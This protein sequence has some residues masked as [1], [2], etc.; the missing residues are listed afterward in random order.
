MDSQR[1]VSISILSDDEVPKSIN[2]DLYQPILDVP[3][4]V[5]H[6][7][8]LSE[9]HELL[10][11]LS[12]TIQRETDVLKKVLTSF[13]DAA[14]LSFPMA[15][16]PPADAE[17]EDISNTTSWFWDADVPG[18]SAIPLCLRRQAISLKNDVARAGEEVQL[19]Q[20]EMVAYITYFVKERIAIQRAIGQ[21]GHGDYHRGAGACLRAQV[22]AVEYCLRTSHAAFAKHID[23]DLPQL[24]L[25]Q[26][27]VS[28]MHVELEPTMDSDLE[29]PANPDYVQS[30]E[31]WEDDDEG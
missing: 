3:I 25:V 29:E 27:P 4:P 18:P 13:N 2:V 12:K 20:A 23:D 7:Q 1:T 28:D 21:L 15:C 11:R 30:E 9:G 22:L 16:E 19:L 8:L 26:W 5:C 14:K 24:Q 31:E 6:L 17:W 10:S